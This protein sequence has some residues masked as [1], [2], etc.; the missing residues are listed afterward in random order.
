MVDS[1]GE[2]ISALDDEDWGVREDAAAAL[3]RLGDPRSVQPLIRA[4]RDSDRAV[5]E[6]AT[7]ALKA[8]GE[9]A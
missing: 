3:G 6:A 2:N 4:L 9:P 8:L 7:S 5:R 1:V